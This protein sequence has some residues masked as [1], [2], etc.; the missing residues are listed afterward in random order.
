MF[1][2]HSNEEYTQNR[3]D[4]LTSGNQCKKIQGHIALQ[5]LINNAE[6]TFQ[7]LDAIW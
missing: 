3:Y 1:L 7:I 6:K 4:Y 5:V 2:K